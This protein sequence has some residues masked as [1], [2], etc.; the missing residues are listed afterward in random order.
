MIK[1][2]LVLASVTLS[3]T[4]FGQSF[5]AKYDFASVTSTSGTTDPTPPPTVTGVTFGTFT[6]NGVSANP[7]AAGRFSFTSWTTGS[8]AGST[9]PAAMTGAMD[10]TDYYEVTLTPEALQFVELDSLTFLL[11]RSG[12]GVR[13]YAVRS[14]IDNYAANLP[15]F[16]RGGNTDLEIISTNTFFLK[17]DSVYRPTPGTGESSGQGSTI[18]FGPEFDN[19]TNPVTLRFYAWNAEGTGGTF[20]VDDVT[21]FGDVFQTPTG[22]SAVAK[23]PQVRIFPNPSTTGVFRVESKDLKYSDITLF[24]V[25][26]SIKEINGFE[27]S[28]N[29]GTLDLSSLARGVYYIK[30]KNQPVKKIVIDK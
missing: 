2:L 5:T 28:N 17:N 25:L 7:S 21:F 16:V 23:D 6:A 27:E 29:G 18:V 10:L 26:G 11:Q 1:P 9:D 8:T 22:V 3:L 20:S 4:S 19:L 15:A 30:I 13:M 14:S 24:D 12:T